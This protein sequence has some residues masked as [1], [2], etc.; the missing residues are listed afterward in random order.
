MLE[1]LC[2]MLVAGTQGQKPPWVEVSQLAELLLKCDHR[3]RRN[4]LRFFTKLIS[5]S[6]GRGV[7]KIRKRGPRDGACAGVLVAEGLGMLYVQGKES[8]AGG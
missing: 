1:K 6:P 2:G 8:N 3:R 7:S 4:Q 5:M